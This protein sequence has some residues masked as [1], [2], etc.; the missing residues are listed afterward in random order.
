MNTAQQPGP[1]RQFLDF[2]AQGKIML[3]RSR[4]TGKY[5]YFPRAA[6]RTARSDE[7]E[8]VEVSRTGIVAIARGPEGM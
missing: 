1:E 8:W 3:Q 5:F 2:L 6:T 4:R 7:M